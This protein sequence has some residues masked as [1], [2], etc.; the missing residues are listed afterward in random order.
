ML[1]TNSFPFYWFLNFFFFVFLCVEQNLSRTGCLRSVID[2]L[3]SPVAAEGRTNT[4][5]LNGRSLN[6]LEAGDVVQ[7]LPHSNRRF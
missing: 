6:A 4:F 1:S 7:K 3:I 5:A 2:N